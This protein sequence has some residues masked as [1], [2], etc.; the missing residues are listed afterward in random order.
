[1]E[2]SLF[3]RMTRMGRIRTDFFLVFEIFLKIRL[4]P[5]NQRH[6]RGKALF[7]FRY[8]DHLCHASASR[9]LPPDFFTWAARALSFLTGFTRATTAAP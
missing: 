3:T 5:R 4:D 8:T 2:K 6:P 9:P 1:M 7:D